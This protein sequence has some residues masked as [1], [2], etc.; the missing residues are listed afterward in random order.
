MYQN[1]EFC[2]YNDEFC[3][4]EKRIYNRPDIKVNFAFKNDG[5]CITNDEF[6]IENDELCEDHHR[7][8]AGFPDV[9]TISGQPNGHN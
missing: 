5:L 1:E 6:C 8:Q 7:G 3:S 9:P 4:M 2:I